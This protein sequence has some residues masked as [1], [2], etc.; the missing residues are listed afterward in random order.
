M[1]IFDLCSGNSILLLTDSLS[2]YQ[3]DAIGP[4][5]II[6]SYTNDT[7]ILTCF[8][9]TGNAITY[10][11]LSPA[12]VNPLNNGEECNILQSYQGKNENKNSGE[13]SQIVTCSKSSLSSSMSSLKKCSSQ[14]LSLD[15][16]SAFRVGS[17]P[18]HCQCEQHTNLTKSLK[19]RK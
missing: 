11:V 19:S 18:Q 1:I 17:I 12:E 4:F 13:L 14:Y 9:F 16:L 7:V 6:P 15:T 3:G 2:D 8:P 10:H 5:F